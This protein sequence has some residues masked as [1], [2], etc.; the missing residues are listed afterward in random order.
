MAKYLKQDSDLGYVE[1]S[2]EIEYLK[3]NNLRH[4]I[5]GYMWGDFNSQGE[6]VLSPEIKHEMIA[7][8]KCVV[9]AIDNIEVCLS[10][11]KFDK[12]ITFIVTTEGNRATLSLVE[13]MNFEANNKL[14]SGTYSN[15][16]EYILDEVETSGVVDKNALY[17]RW[18]ISS[19]PGE[20]LDVFYMD[21]ESL[22]S[23]FGLTARF[24]YLIKANEILLNQEEQLEEIEAEYSVNLLSIIDHYPKMKVLVDEE[25]KKTLSEKKDFIRIDRPNFAKTLNEVIEKS[26]YANLNALTEEERAEFLSERHNVQVAYNIKSR[27]A[28][29]IKSETLEIKEEHIGDELS[30]TKKDKIILDTHNIE[31]SRS[32]VELMQETLQAEKNVVE[33]NVSEAIALN[34]GDVANAPVADASRLLVAIGDGGVKA[35]LGKRQVQGEEISSYRAELYRYLSSKGATVTH[36]TSPNTSEQISQIE[37]KRLANVNAE[38]ASQPTKT[39]SKQVDNKPK[40]QAT[41]DKSAG[42]SSGGGGG[43]ASKKPSA[44]TAKRVSPTTTASSKASQSTNSGHGLIR[45]AVRNANVNNRHEID[46]TISSRYE[47]KHKDGEV[48]SNAEFGIGNIEIDNFNAERENLIQKSNVAK[49]VPSSQKETEKNVQIS[50]D[51]SVSI[52]P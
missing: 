47:Q 45:G 25:L 49:V 33:R 31:Q 6:Y 29:D 10:N 22:A 44:K 43:N 8:Q 39:N 18:N 12:Q 30:A 40:S 26:M 35:I 2:A 17:R 36:N 11:I 19:T 9:D 34:V 14:N 42:S 1:D 7:M 16:N 46:G 13:K 48:A 20:V 23:L 28:V 15:I 5:L 51:E 52:E 38:Q 37:K 3:F 24:K 50:R 32:I 27:D 41:V 4:T 21:E